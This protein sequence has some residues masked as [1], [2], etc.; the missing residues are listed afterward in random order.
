M[1]RGLI[2]GC[3]FINHCKFLQNNHRDISE[4]SE[5]IQLG[6]FANIRPMRSQILSPFIV[7]G[8]AQPKG[9]EGRPGIS[10]AGPAQTASDTPPRPHRLQSP[11]ASTPQTGSFAP[12]FRTLTSRNQ[13]RRSISRLLLG[14]QRRNFAWNFISVVGFCGIFIFQHSRTTRP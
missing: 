1:R 11:K 13:L 4:H 8:G 5:E 10:L 12:L 6:F 2:F 9:L 14:L 3:S 7:V